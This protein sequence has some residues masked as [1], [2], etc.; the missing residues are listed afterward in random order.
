MPLFALICGAILV[1]EATSL[2][3]F[4]QYS[5]LGAGFMPL[6][7]GM[8]LLLIGLGLGAQVLRGVRFNPEE[9]EGADASAPVSR[10]GLC[11]AA[12]AVGSPIVTFPVLGFPLGG[13]LA[14]MLV[15]RAFG[16]RNSTL[17]C[18]IGIA[19]SAAAWFAFSKLGVQLGPF[20]PFGAR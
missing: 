15:A 1:L 2:P 7:V 19:L 11:L 18:I 9:A 12:L 13:A 6:A 4:E 16:S 8:G 10:L 3:L 17:D 5:G 14:F 20:L